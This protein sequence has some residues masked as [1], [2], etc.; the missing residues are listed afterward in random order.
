MHAAVFAGRENEMAHLS[1]ALA[2]VNLLSS[3][4]QLLLVGYTAG[5]SLCKTTHHSKE[6]PP[7][8]R[9]YG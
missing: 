4:I 7:A 8:S 3:M 5:L 6:Q 9:D 2:A 1:K